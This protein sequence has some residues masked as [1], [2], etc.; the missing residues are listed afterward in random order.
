MGR[1]AKYIGCKFKD[2]YEKHYAREFCRKHAA[3]FYK[4]NIEEDGSPKESYKP[5]IPCCQF[6]KC[7]TKGT[8]KASLRNGLCNKHRKWV[9]KGIIDRETYEVLLPERIPKT[10]LPAVAFVGGKTH[11]FKRKCK[12]EECL[13]ESRRNGFCG[14]HSSSFYAGKKDAEGKPLYDRQYYTEHTVC[15][16]KDCTIK[17]PKRFS[18]GFCLYHYERYRK[19]WLSLKGNPTKKKDQRFKENRVTP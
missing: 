17:N 14:S 8:A 11:I 2:C 4:G 7:Y 10:Y 18:K 13:K 1:G 15:K 12:I 3:A 16:V 6:P 9:E 19:G 5:L